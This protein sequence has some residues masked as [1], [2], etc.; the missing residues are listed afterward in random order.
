MG[1]VMAAL[2]DEDTLIGVGTET[3]TFS[4]MGPQEGCTESVPC[5]PRGASA[6]EVM[7][8]TAHVQ[9]QAT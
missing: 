8:R 2:R 7:A 3:A 1:R 5:G 6:R 4:A 9:G